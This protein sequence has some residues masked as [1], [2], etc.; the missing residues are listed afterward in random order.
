[1]G[2]ASV[3]A[4]DL[5]TVYPGAATASARGEHAV[6]N[7][8]AL[9]AAHAGGSSPDGASHSFDTESGHAAL[10]SPDSRIGTLASRPEVGRT[11]GQP[12]RIVD[13][14]AVA[15]RRLSGSRRP[16]GWAIGRE[17][18]S[19]QRRLKPLDRRAHGL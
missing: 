9:A 12:A 1:M 10:L 3:L 8:Q 11:V 18:V 6:T 7:R 5:A 16:G 13:K 15:E 2:V 4:A 17:P 19:P 14:D